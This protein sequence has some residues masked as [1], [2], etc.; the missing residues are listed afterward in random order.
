LSA[1]VATKTLTMWSGFLTGIFMLGIVF[2]RQV[3]AL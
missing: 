3:N 2:P 1:R